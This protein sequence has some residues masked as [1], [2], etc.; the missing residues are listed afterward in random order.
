MNDQTIE[1]PGIDIEPYLAD[2]LES[3]VETI[4]LFGEYPQPRPNAWRT[5]KTPPKREFDLYDFLEAHEGDPYRMPEE[6]TLREYFIL[7][8]TDRT[9]YGPFSDARDRWEKK[10]EKAL[11]DDLAG[12]E[13]VQAKALQLAL[14]EREEQR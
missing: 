13:L 7:S 9:T 12:G 14:E 3:V 6:C 1:A 11:R 8:L 2:A 10:I 5:G 4:L